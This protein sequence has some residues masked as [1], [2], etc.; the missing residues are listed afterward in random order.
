MSDR[1]SAS[2]ANNKRI[3]KNTALLYVRMLFLLVISLYT[4]RVVLKTLGISDFGLYNVVGGF[5]SMLAFVTNSLSGATSRFITFEL[6]KGDL[7]HVEKVFR[8]SSTIYYVF[9]LIAL[10]LAETVGLWFVLNKLNFPPDRIEAV[11]W[12]YQF[13][14]VTFLIGIISIPYNALIIA[15]ERMNAFAYISIFEGL[16]K[17]GVVYLISITGFDRLIVY[18]FLLMVVQ[19][20]IRVVYNVY[21][22]RH[23]QEVNGAWLWDNEFSR[24]IFVFAGWILNGNLAVI[25]FTQGLN[26]LLNMFFGPVVNAARAISVQIQGVANQFFG[27]F[28]TAITPQ[29]VKSYAQN[30]LEYMHKLIINSSKYSFYIILLI[31]FP[32]CVNIEYLLH[33]WL[34]TYPAHTVSFV[35]IML[36]ASMN[37]TLS[38]PIINAIH[39]T[40]DLRKFQ[41]I[42]GSLLLLI[43][44][45]AYV[46]LKTLHISPEQTLLVYV[47]IEFITQFVR[48][49]IV[50]PKISMSF[51][52]Y[53]TDILWPISRPIF[54]LTLF[55]V[56]YWYNDYHCSSFIFF[57]GNSLF[58]V[59]LSA[60]TIYFCGM[61]AKERVFC[62]E[63]VN[64]FVHKIKR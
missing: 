48:V 32:I 44:P 37:Q 54:I 26:V 29:L 43:V 62:M 50:Y 5:I 2:Q 47:V 60:L 28:M 31:A 33:L 1:P 59:C 35:M 13:S 52:L 30:N 19:I 56:A 39:A 23:F 27:N 63:K 46:L 55:G 21:C 49:W 38:T 34:G 7:S 53:F 3:A 16:A 64:T 42:E 58:C 10:F 51:R 8:C 17:L 61:N 22:K 20:V 18:A 45:I 24:K 12:V 57:L 36:I 4:S 11:F 6:G 9:S 14:I 25:G 41:L 15:H 40:G